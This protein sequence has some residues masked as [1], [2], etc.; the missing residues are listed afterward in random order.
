[1]AT[2]YRRRHNLVITTLG[3]ALADGSGTSVTFASA[4]KEGGSGGTN[5]ATLG[6]DEY[7]P[8]TIENEV[9]YLSAYTAGATTGTIVR[10]QE[11]TTGVAHGINVRV[12]HALT[13]LDGG[14]VRY[15]ALRITSGDYGTG[16]VGAGW[17]EPFGSASD[18]T[19]AAVAGDLV[20][21]SL[22]AQ[23]SAVSA[24]ID[25]LDVVLVNSYQH[26][27]DGGTGAVA[28][29][30]G[31]GAP[32]WTSSNS[33]SVDGISGSLFYVVQSGDVA[34]GNVSFRAITRSTS[35]RTLKATSAVPFLFTVLNHRVPV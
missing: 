11:G 25:Y 19:I 20:E 2:T 10:A 1:M 34:S 17:R 26:I 5:I 24:S 27:G 33:N 21:V 22:N 16:S 3:A 9:V 8:L 18:I 4:L 14:G 23:W 31:T 30:T 28:S 32:G 7:L 6:T 13:K 29:T 12:A 15:G 35:G